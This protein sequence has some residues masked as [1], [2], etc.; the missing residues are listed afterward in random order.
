MITT[1]PNSLIDRAYTS[2]APVSTPRSP[3]G[4]VTRRNACQGVAPRL[5]AARSSRGSMVS[6]ATRALLTANG[7]LTNSIAATMPHWD[8]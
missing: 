7:Q 3:S 6:N 5:R 4:R 8:P 1:A 2:T